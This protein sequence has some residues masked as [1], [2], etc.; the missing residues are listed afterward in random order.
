MPVLNSKYDQLFLNDEYLTDP[1][2]LA[3]AWKKAH[4][5]RR[6]LYQISGEANLYGHLKCPL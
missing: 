5:Y 1:L 6:R 2:L 3:L 4:D